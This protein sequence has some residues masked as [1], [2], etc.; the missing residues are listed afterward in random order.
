MTNDIHTLLDLANCVVENTR[1]ELLE[2]LQDETIPL[3]IRADILKES[4]CFGIIGNVS[5]DILP[6][7]LKSRYIFDVDDVMELIS[8]GID[9]YDLLEYMVLHTYKAIKP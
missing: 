3:I 4:R 5:K 7:K 9:C 8:R 2:Y 6:E 1:I